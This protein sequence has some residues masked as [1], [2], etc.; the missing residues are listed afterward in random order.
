VSAAQPDDWKPAAVSHAKSEFP[1]EACG[2]VIVQR[3]RARYMPCGNLAR[4]T[5]HFILDPAD[6]ARAEDAGEIVA[7]FHSHPNASCHPSAADR[8]SCETSGLPWH[9]LGLP[10]GAWS[11]CEP[12]GY[13]APLINRPFQHG[14][15]D[16][17]ALVRDWYHRERGIELGDYLRRDQWWKQGENL[18]VEHFADEGFLPIT[19]NQAGPGDLVLFAVE[20][21]VPNHAAI[22]LE[23]NQ[24]L[25]HCFNRL[26]S[27]EVFGGY[28]IRV[29]THY[30][31]HRSCVK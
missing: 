16:C 10:S 9:I 19:F 17:Y 7:V 15:L 3:G 6:Y 14:V 29:A 12:C 18:Y 26:S 21:D 1:R 31:R 2:L 27:R 13:E 28:W 24:M 11:G 22:L 8:V 23:D 5:D 4:G 25:H 20:S 30:L